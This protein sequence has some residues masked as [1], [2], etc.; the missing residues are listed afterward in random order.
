M[1][2]KSIKVKGF[3]SSPAEQAVEFSEG[4]N[5]LYGK[6]ASGKTNLLE[7]IYLC[8]AGKSFR[9]CDEKN[10]IRHGEQRSSIIAEY[11]SEGRDGESSTVELCHYNCGRKTARLFRLNGIKT[12][13]ASEAV[14]NFKAVVFT[15]DHLSIVKGAPEERRRFL[16]MV[17]SQA[18]RSYIGYLTA[19]NKRL[20]YKNDFLR[21]A[22]QKG[23]P[24]DT[25]MLDTVNITLAEYA[26]RVCDM[27][28]KFCAELTEKASEFYSQITGGREKLVLEYES[29]ISLPH[30]LTFEESVSEVCRLFGDAAESEVAAGYALV[31][32]HRDDISIRIENIGES[33]G[34]NENNGEAESSDICT[35]GDGFSYSYSH[36]AKF[37]GSRGQQ[38]SAVLALKLAEGE[39]LRSLT[40]EYPVFLFD[41]VLSELDAERRNFILSELS[42]RQVI[43]TCCDVDASFGSVAN[44]K[45]INAVNGVY[46]G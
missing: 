27:R 22:K 7:A 24:P 43:V 41:D 15:P 30:G 44:A 29:K 42:G 4:V 16:D 40:G 12:E 34:E 35:D 3:R 38:R 23:I 10:F 36:S 6:N 20:R 19:Y 21:I 28:R 13:S 33:Q 46:Q 11:V 1:V 37:F 31:G 14:G 39:M 25:V 2:L 26:V 45:L 5:V 18:R 8:A 32:P 9:L 17:M